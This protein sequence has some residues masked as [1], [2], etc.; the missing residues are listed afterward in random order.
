MIYPGLALI[1]ALMGLAGGAVEDKA[2]QKDFGKDWRQILRNKN[3][4]IK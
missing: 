4:Q 2:M 3:T 1:A